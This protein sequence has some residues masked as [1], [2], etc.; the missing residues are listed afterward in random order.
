MPP[1][2]KQ[3]E[4]ATELVKT[5]WLAGAKGLAKISEKGL[6]KSGTKLLF[7]THTAEILEKFIT[8]DKDMI[9]LKE[10]CQRLQAEDDPVLIIGE[11][12]TGKELIAQSLHGSRVGQF[13]DVNCTSLPDQLLESELFGH[14]EGAY[15]GADKDRAGAFRAAFNGTIFLDEIGDMPL[16]MQTKLLRVLQEK[17]VKPV[18]T[19]VKDKVNCRVIA[20]TNRTL[21]EL[22]EKKHF[23]S[24]L[25]Y[26]LNVFCLHT[27]PLRDRLD[28]I[29]HIVDSL[30]GEKLV[31]EFE[32]WKTTE[33]Y[34]MQVQLWTTKRLDTHLMT[35]KT[36]FH[37]DGN[38]RS[39][40]AQVK[41]YLVLGEL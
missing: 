40:Q 2:I 11:S 9:T 18:G 26:R 21:V 28:D 15:T 23:R 1:T 12:G 38:V 37:L 22:M 33:E 6:L 17:E 8:V 32:K 35:Y 3:P 5:P 14:V 36:F 4:N 7:S 24:D 30:G 10:K 34:I 20:A 31:E 27:K 39:L 19:D 41:R 25:L 13:I 16:N 29:E